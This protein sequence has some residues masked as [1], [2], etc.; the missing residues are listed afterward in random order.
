MTPEQKR[1]ETLSN[2]ETTIADAATEYKAQ[3]DA[4]KDDGM[5]IEAMGIDLAGD[6]SN[7]L[8]EILSKREKRLVVVALMSNLRDCCADGMITQEEMDGLGDRPNGGH[9]LGEAILNI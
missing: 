9:S 2:I 6:I 8:D 1:W 5:I 7:G 3:S 4:N